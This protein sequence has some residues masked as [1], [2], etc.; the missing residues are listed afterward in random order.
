MG[1]RRLFTLKSV[2]TFLQTQNLEFF[3]ADIFREQIEREFQK[4]KEQY[5]KYDKFFE[6]FMEDLEQKMAEDLESVAAFENKKRKRTYVNSKKVDSIEKKITECQDI[7]KNKMIIEFN[8]SEPSSVR[9]TAVK[10][11]TNIKCTT[12]FV[13]KI[14]NVC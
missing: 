11:N 13:W 1:L 3:S 14:F 9:T 6:F 12:R 5:S 7:R 2:R 10:S 8:D 4:N